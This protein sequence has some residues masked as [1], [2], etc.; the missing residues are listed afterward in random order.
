[1]KM[2]S[3]ANPQFEPPN[4]DELVA[5]LDGE[6]PPEE[7]RA[8]EERLAN[9]ETYRQKLRDLDQAWEALSTL[10]PATVDDS[11]A[12][13]TIELACV[14]AE[15]DLTQLKSLASVENRSRWR[16]WIG[17]GVAT[18]ILGFIIARSIS[19]HRNNALLADLPVIQQAHVLSHVEGI[20]FL[21]QLAKAVPLDELKRD[22]D[23][24]AF[25]RDLEDFRKVNSLSLSERR[26]WVESL[27][28]DEKATLAERA[29]T[30]ETRHQLPAEKNRLNELVREASQDSELEETLIAYG[31]WLGRQ[32]AAQLEQLREN[33]KDVPTAEQ[34]AEV[35]RMVHQEYVQAARHL[36][37]ADAKALRD[38]IFALAKE[39]KPEVLEK[40]PPGREHDRVASLDVSKAG[41]AAFVI[42]RLV[43]DS[44]T[45]KATIDRLLSKLSPETRDHWN[46]LASGLRYQLWQWELDALKPQWGQA[47]L[48]QFFASDLT[49]EERQKLLDMPRSEMK[50]RLE[51]MY[52][53]SKFG[54][55]NRA[56]FFRDFGDGMRGF[57]GGPPNMGRPGERGP[58]FG[59]GGRSGEPRFERGRPEREM[60]PDGRRGPL[61]ED[62]LDEPRGE[63]RHRPP[64]DGPPPGGPPNDQPPPPPP[65]KNAQPI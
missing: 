18:A 34:V 2:S 56:E 5:Y 32:S 10:P 39:K 20:G 63:R 23:D 4:N 52:L 8:V 30:F 59:S 40:I 3:I 13:T 6:L 44:D 60:G 14:Q 9:D 62:R 42:H 26:D 17:G 54:I 57:G 58:G 29:R 41:A 1:M 24:A 35:R 46:Q 28:S 11:F 31:E 25:Q 50:S 64:D 47:E 49:P 15:D 22:K 36:S 16:W 65:P 43:W 37:P 7:C 53:S 27:S 38:E 61:P 12:R 21:R 33:T 55:D 51:Q 19:A 48:E 45:H